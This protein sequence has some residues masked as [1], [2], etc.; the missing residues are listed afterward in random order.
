M[1]LRLLNEWGALLVM[2]RESTAML[3]CDRNAFDG[4][5]VEL[6]EL[7]GDVTAVLGLVS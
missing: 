1:E 4:E 5:V 3:L 6:K 2:L 7:Y